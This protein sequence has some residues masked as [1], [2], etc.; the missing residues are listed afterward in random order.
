MRRL[1]SSG[2][3]DVLPT[4]LCVS[5]ALACVAAMNIA[6]LLAQSNEPHP[7]FEVASVKPSSPEL[8]AQYPSSG[9]NQ[10]R[11]LIRGQNLRLII[12]LAYSID[13]PLHEMKVV[14]RAKVL[15]DKFDI[16]A[17]APATIPP[18]NG[19]EMLKT[20]LRER[21]GL[22]I[23]YEQRVL[24]VYSLT[25]VRQDGPLGGSIRSSAHDC[26]AYIARRRVDP[27]SVSTADMRICASPWGYDRLGAGTMLMEYA[28][29]ISALVRILQPLVDRVIV[30]ST[31]LQGTFEWSLGFRTNPDSNAGVPVL[32]S[33]LERQLGLRLVA[34]RSAVEVLVVDQVFAPTPN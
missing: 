3:N 26:E 24:P 14:G 22:K 10:R 33:A 9:W 21:F 2:H 28:G 31:G 5:F 23:R 34:T 18:A 20:L 30:D 19:R 7:A 15:S 1:P 8:R 17:L 16:E 13:V 25:R 11:I 32:F 4:R 12:A 27:D 29:Q 6:S